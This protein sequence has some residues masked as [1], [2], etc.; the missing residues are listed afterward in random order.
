M[1]V[2]AKSRFARALRILG[3]FAF[4]QLAIWP[5]MPWASER[6]EM[7]VEQL[8]KTGR[9]LV[10]KTHYLEALDLFNEAR[11]ILEVSGG[12]DGEEYG[13]V[14]F[15]S[16]QAK[17][18][19]RIHQGFPA[20][21]VKSALKDIQESNSLREK[22]TDVLPQKMS[23]GYYLEGFIHKKFFRRKKAALS[24]FIK[25]VNLDPSNSA[26]KRELSEL[27]TSGDGS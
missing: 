8:V 1:S 21:Y 23:K 25:S 7:L 3:L 6:P 17:I 26:A 15:D 19:G 20:S 11:D 10:E 9:I 12:R 24:C 14:L 5:A 13:D 16:A 27:V 22:L 4:A 18:K 2:K